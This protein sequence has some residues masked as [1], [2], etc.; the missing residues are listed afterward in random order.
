[1][2]IADLHIHSRFSRATS[3]DCDAPHLDHWA[4]LKGIGLVGTGDFT[5]PQWRE[6]LRA[7]LE[8]AEDGLYRLRD[9]CRLPCPL[10]G[11]IEDPRFVV[12]GEISTIYKKNGRT[13]KVH[14]VILLP[15]LD[16]AETLA[17]RLEAIGNLHSDGRPILGLDSHDLL[18]IVLDSCPDAVYIPAHIWTPHFSVFGAFSGFE[19]LEE[20]YGDLT[21]QIH[22]LETGLSSDPPMNRRLS[23]LDGYLLVSNSDAHSP[24]RLGR[25][26]N[27]LDCARSYPALKHALD[28]GEGFAGTIEFYPEEGKYHLDGHRA[29]DCC[30]EPEETRRL[31]GRCPVCGRKLTVGVLHRVEELADRSAPAADASPFYRPFESWIP[32]PEL[33]ADCYG[34]SASSKRVQAAYMAALGRFGPE[35]R[36]LRELPPEAL[37]DCC[38]P[39]AGEALRRLRRGEVRRKAGYDGVYGVISLFA[40]GEQAALGG[41]LAMPGLEGLAPRRRKLAEKPIPAADASAAAAPEETAAEDLNPAQRSAVLAEAPVVAVI[42]GPGTGKTRTLTARIARLVAEGTPPESITAVTFTRQAAAEMRT[43]LETALGPQ[44]AQALTIGTFHAVALR[45]LPE[46]AI[47]TGAAAQAV[48]KDVLK[49]ADCPLA[50]AEFLSRLSARKNGMPAELP[51]AAA[52]AYAEALAARNVRDLDDILLEALAA[53]PADPRPF[54]HLLVDEFQDINALQHRLVQHWAACGQSLFVIGDPDQSIYGFRGADA[55]CFARLRAAHPEAA[56]IALEENYRSTPAVLESA[57]AVI[58][59]NPGAPRA[60]RAYRPAGAPVRVVSAGDALGEGIWI[61]QEIERMA[62]G[63]DMV[64]AQDAARE[65]GHTRAFSEIAVLCRTRRQLERLEDCLAHDGIP[66]ALSGRD[67]ALNDKKV[68]ALLGFFRFL[69]RHADADALEAALTGLFGATPAL[70]RRAASAFRQLD[71]PDLDAVRADFSAHAPLRL[72]LEAA[73]EFLPRLSDEKPRRLLE[74]LGQRC[75]VKGKP[76]ERLLNM[77]VFHETMTDFLEALLLG[78]EGDIKRLAAPKYASGAVRLMTLHAAKGLEFPVVFLAG[79]ARGELPLERADG[80]ADTEEER[81]LF[82]VG[83]TR[84]REELILTHSGAP[85]PFL[86]ELPDSIRRERAESKAKLSKGIQLSMF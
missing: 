10:P 26:A 62:G 36:I 29:C 71:A 44:R 78:E 59:R 12:T 60:L 69:E 64:D 58:G 14:H 22:A 27:F 83:L 46:K 28:T 56:F 75:G 47:L 9:E 6:E 8:P 31:E 23:A 84:A 61:A 24:S 72:F 50:P 37:A 11:P 16:A 63:I 32:L 68:N 38:G 39:L 34:V 81:R 54:T 45:Q 43:R 70:A 79:V 19:T 73:D 41:Q 3:R 74:Q 40:P 25:E 66:C 1:M 57:M 52:Q 65:Q 77:A 7:A 53:P 2:Y 67:E 55:G 17:H 5:H 85:S 42:A 48:A 18:E 30:L 20:C 80:P 15:S 33:L 51:E 21:G 76:I 35:F 13:R 82:F 86:A 4:R 49:A